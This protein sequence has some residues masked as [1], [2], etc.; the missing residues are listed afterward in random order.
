MLR[1][2]ALS[3]FT[4]A[5]CDVV[6]SYISFPFHRKGFIK[7]WKWQSHRRKKQKWQEQVYFCHFSYL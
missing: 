2:T 6:S 3:R 5:L 7:A 1:D 4:L